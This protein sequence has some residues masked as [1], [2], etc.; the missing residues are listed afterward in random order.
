M[1]KQFLY[2]FMVDYKTISGTDMHQCFQVPAFCV[3]NN[4]VAAEVL[5]KHLLS[6]GYTPVVIIEVSGNLNMEELE[7]IQEGEIPLSDCVLKEVIDL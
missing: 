1:K 6:I 2:N 4:R 5:K 7:R 3:K